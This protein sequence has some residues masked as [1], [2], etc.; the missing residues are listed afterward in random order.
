MKSCVLWETAASDRIASLSNIESVRQI[1]PFYAFM[2][3]MACALPGGFKAVRICTATTHY[4]EKNQSHVILIVSSLLCFFFFSF[5]VFSVAYALASTA[6]QLYRIGAWQSGMNGC[7]LIVLK[8]PPPDC[9]IP[10]GNAAPPADRLASDG[11][12]PRAG[13]A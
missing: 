4:R 2:D 11:A 12:A 9:P 6:P 5:A 13:G 3:D 7:F 8:I 10:A 1:P